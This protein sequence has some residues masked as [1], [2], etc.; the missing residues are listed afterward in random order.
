MR[1]SKEMVESEDEAVKFL[2]DSAGST[3][4]CDDCGNSHTLETCPKVKESHREH[5]NTP[6]SLFIVQVFLKSYRKHLLRQLLPKRM[7]LWTL[8]TVSFP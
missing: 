4:K 7:L 3:K 8:T 2:E 1:L 5:K 6:V